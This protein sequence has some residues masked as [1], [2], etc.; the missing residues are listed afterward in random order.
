MVTSL[1]VCG[2]RLLSGSADRSVR[3]WAAAGAGAPPA[4]ERALLGHAGCVWSLAAWRGKAVSGAADSAIRVW[5]AATGAHDATL[6][7]H[8]GAVCALA[9]HGGRRLLLSACYDGTVRAW[10]LGTWEALRTVEAYGPGTGQHVHCLAVCGSKLVGGSRATGGA[11]REVRARRGR[12]GL[13][14][15]WPCSGRDCGQYLT[16]I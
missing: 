12:W 13:T 11:R 2:P 14:T 15:I 8:D 5:D 10:A 16:P 4:C 9:A 1:A 6:A 7:G 3:V